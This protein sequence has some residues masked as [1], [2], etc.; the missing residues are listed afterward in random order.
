M[1]RLL[2]LLSAVVLTTTACTDTIG[3]VDED[4]AGFY[5]LIAIGGD[6]LP[7]TFED[8]DTLQVEITAA[9]IFMGIN[10]VYREVDTF[11]LTRESGVT[12]QVDTFTADWIIG[13]NNVLTVTTQTSQG[14][15]SFS[16]GWNGANTLTFRVGSVDWVWRHR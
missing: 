11:R 16:G 1:P 6:P 7:I 10:G 15:Q 3:G 5:D 8:S 13:P 9:E 14:P 4:I 12:M 2:M